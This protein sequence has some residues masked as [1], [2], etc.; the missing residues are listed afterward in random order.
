MCATS[1]KI[2]KHLQLQT[3]SHFE[4]AL[5]ADIKRIG[6]VLIYKLIKKEIFKN[7]KF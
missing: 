7:N 1:L 3:Q 5:S 6:T 4:T 2:L